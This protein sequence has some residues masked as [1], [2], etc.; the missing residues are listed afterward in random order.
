MRV[1]DQYFWNIVFTLFFVALVVMG[2]IILDTEAYKSYDELLLV[3]FLLITLA[4]FRLIRLFVYDNIT[5]FFR[6]QF[7]DAKVSKTSVELT[8]PVRGPRRTIADLLS[9]PWCI[10]IWMSAIVAFFY[11]LTPYAFYIT[12]F[13]A[14]AGVATFLQLLSNMIG[15]RAEQ[16]K[17]EV[18]RRF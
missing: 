18:E 13:L 11:L 4:T 2:T 12:L 6:E 9:C 3:D 14:L 17:N 8:K 7:W 5:A 15:W 16:L 10:G 1:T